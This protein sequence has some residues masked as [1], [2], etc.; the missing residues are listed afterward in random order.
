MTTPY[1]YLIGWKKLDVWYGGVRYKKDCTPDDLFKTYFTSSKY[2]KRFIEEHGYPDHKEIIKVFTDSR[3][4][5]DFEQTF[6]TQNDVL[7]K[8]NWL[9]RAIGGHFVGTHGPL[10]EETKRKI[11]KAHKGKKCKPISEEQKIKQK[12]TYKRNYYADFEKSF[13]KKSKEQKGKIVSLQT[14][15]KLSLANIGK[16][17]DDEIKRKISNS[18]KG[19]KWFTDGVTSKFR[20]ECPDGFRAGRIINKSK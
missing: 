14:K 8:E 3:E 18:N 12:E 15:K 11:S 7:N 10:S 9:N 16:K 20:Y 2:V 17:M 5:R 1:V 13:A 19:K 4:A 6:L